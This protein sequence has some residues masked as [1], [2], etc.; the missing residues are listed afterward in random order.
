MKPASGADPNTRRF[1][2]SPT[3]GSATPS[4]QAERSLPR[5]KTGDRIH[6]VAAGSTSHG[7]PAFCFL[8]GKR[9]RAK[10]VLQVSADRE[11]WVP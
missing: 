4:Q 10:W 11:P 3:P 9:G 5:E 8:M 6:G 7:D 1:T 2:P